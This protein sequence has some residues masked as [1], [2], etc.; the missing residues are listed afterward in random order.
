MPKS[1]SSISDDRITAEV[2]PSSCQSGDT[3]LL[4]EILG[5]QVNFSSDAKEM[6]CGWENDS[7]K[8]G[9]EILRLPI[10][11]KEDCWGTVQVKNMYEVYSWRSSASKIDPDGDLELIYFGLFC[12][13][14]CSKNK[15]FTWFYP[16]QSSFFFFNIELVFAILLVDKPVL[17]NS[18]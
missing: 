16:Q 4:R 11:E 15:H 1:Q 14:N 3:S 7:R 18:Q 8:R 12:L 13:P 9:G 6:L 5:P 10:R 2:A 17:M